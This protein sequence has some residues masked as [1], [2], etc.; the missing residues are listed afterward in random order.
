MNSDTISNTVVVMAKHWQSG[1]V[2]T[3]LAASIGS[4]IAREVYRKMA[5]QYWQQLEN[6][7]WQRHLWSA[8]HGSAQQLGAW[9][10]G[11]DKLAVQSGDDLG[12][13]MLNA[14]ANTKYKEW[15]A[16]SGTDCPRLSSSY[17]AV[18]CEH[19]EDH[20]VCIAPTVDGGYAFMAMK[21]VHPQL[22]QNIDWST[23]Q[24]LRQT[25]EI[26]QAAQLKVFL[27]QELRDLDD[28]D[29]LNHFAENGDDWARI[30]I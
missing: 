14:L 21:V 22:F 28:I 12:A 11:H 24:V 25:L 4:N 3:R 16:V 23:S 5:H 2:K 7:Q 17:I 13:R 27:G 15:L 30:T 8:N 20:D 1:P 9:L 19:L 29:D 6:R 18:L 10:S 26:A